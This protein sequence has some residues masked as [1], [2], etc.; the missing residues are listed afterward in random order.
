[1]AVDVGVDN[2]NSSI[3]RFRVFE[4]TLVAVEF[5][6]PTT[7][8]FCLHGFVDWCRFASTSIHCPSA[9]D[10]GEV[11]LARLLLFLLACCLPPCLLPQVPSCAWV[12]RKRLACSKPSLRK[13]KPSSRKR[14][15]SLRKR[16]SSYASVFEWLQAE[17]AR[18]VLKASVKVLIEVLV[19]A[20]ACHCRKEGWPARATHPTGL[21]PVRVQKKQM[22]NAQTNDSASV[23]LVACLQSLSSAINAVCNQ[24]RLAAWAQNV[25]HLL[26]LA[27]RAVGSFKLAAGPFGAMFPPARVGLIGKDGG[28]RTAVMREEYDKAS[29]ICP[30]LWVECSVALGRTFG[31]R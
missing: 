15:P 13:S 28:M 1:M 2:A 27:H 11:L 23:A 21:F 29:W 8:V 16:Y 5:N 3:L 19:K 7:E 9:A 31:S 4:A 25:S 17:H 26:K 30:G 12:S 22:E 6:V 24:R 20:I 10:M 14:K 18:A